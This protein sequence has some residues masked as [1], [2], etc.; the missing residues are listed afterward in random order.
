[1]EAMHFYFGEKQCL[2][3]H[4]KL[5]LYIYKIKALAQTLSFM[6]VF[7]LNM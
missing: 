1:M 6:P 2:S 5:I 7:M 4:E 3:F